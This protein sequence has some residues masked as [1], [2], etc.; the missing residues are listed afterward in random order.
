MDTGQEKRK[1]IA[2]PLKVPIP[3][4]REVPVEPRKVEEPALIPARQDR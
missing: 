2:E 1:G 3:V 4:R